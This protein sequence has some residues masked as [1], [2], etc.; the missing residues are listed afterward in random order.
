MS[1]SFGGHPRF[2]S[3]PSFTGLVEYESQTAWTSIAIT[4]LVIVPLLILL[5]CI[6]HVS[7]KKSREKGT[8]LLWDYTSTPTLRRRSSIA[9]LSLLNLT[10]TEHLQPLRR[11]NSSPMLREGHIA[12]A[13]TPS[14]GPS[15]QFSPVTPQS[16]PVSVFSDSTLPSTTSHSGKKIRR[17]YDGVYRTGEPLPGKPLIEFEDKVWDLDEEYKRADAKVP[18]DRSLSLYHEAVPSTSDHRRRIQTDIF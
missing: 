18:R 2:K 9:G 11:A 12:S 1:R 15:F 8:G 13:F 4:S 10:E 17:A 7:Y 16:S 3:P 14:P 6:L 5:C